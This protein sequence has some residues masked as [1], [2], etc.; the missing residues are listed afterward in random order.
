MIPDRPWKDLDWRLL[1][2][3]LAI[4][5]L[6]V[7]QIYS[8]TIG[9]KWESAWW[10]QTLFVAAGLG[11]MYLASRVDYHVL[12]DHV[13]A[14]Y[15]ICALALLGVLLLGRQVFGSRRW[16]PL[17]GG[18]TLQVSEFAKI[19]II[20]LIAR[21]LSEL[22]SGRPGL[23]D[24][25]KL[26]GFVAVPAALVLKQPDLGTSL[27]YVAI[28]GAGLFFAGLR[29]RH[30]ALILALAAVVVAASP[31][32]LTEYQKARIESFRN[33]ASDPLGSGYQVL[34]SMI[35][36]GSGGIWGKGATQGSQTQLR[37]L[38]V[39]HTDF[40]LSA[41][42]E[43]HGFAGVTLILGLYFLLL[44]QIVQIA[45]AA[46]DRAG[47]YVCMGVGALLLFQLF[48]NV[49]MLVGRMVVTGLPLPL[50]SYG[51][52]SVLTTFLMLGLVSNVR[53]QRFVN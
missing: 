5:A 12:L 8:A 32:F 30:W 29:W 49:G 33:P 52:S 24:V 4:S 26:G 15:G 17:P 9:T 22:K 21:Y 37:F 7:V 16:I 35:A 25:L 2:L 19:I 36:V 45:Q 38:P 23:A 41:F 46:P 27:T 40:V 10:K 48:V 47:M 1:L 20:L 3:A 39:P 11:V 6:G 34:Q 50:M 44:M 43:E 13:P 53:F 42:A 31:L 28:A 51:G 18:F 14:L